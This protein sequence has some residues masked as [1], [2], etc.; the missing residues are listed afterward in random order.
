MENPLIQVRPESRRKPLG[1][2]TQQANTT[3]HSA[4][5]AK[6]RKMSSSHDTTDIPSS[7]LPH[8]ESLNANGPLT[9]R[10]FTTS[11]ENKR[12]SAVTNEDPESK[13][14]SQVST[15]STNASGKTRR[16]K[17][18]VGPWEL[19]S[20]V[21]KG[22]IGRVRKVRHAVTGETAAVKI[23]SKRVAEKARAESL[24]NLVESSKSKRHSV[25]EFSHVMPF[26]IEREVIIMKLLEHPNIV[27]L[28]DI[29]ENRSEL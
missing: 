22:G 24:A 18:H 23:I 11:P 29:W 10:S 28:Y 12:L 25:A 16:R 4:R 9:V 3:F 5:S 7:D 13:R 20:D 15:T 27:K 6:G 21:G 2:G 17:T 26:G 14:N 8:H 19:G 1:D